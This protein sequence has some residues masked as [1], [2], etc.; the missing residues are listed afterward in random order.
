MSESAAYKE[1]K[2]AKVL[3][4]SLVKKPQSLVSLTKGIILL[5]SMLLL[6]ALHSEH[7]ATSNL[8]WIDQGIKENNMRPYQ[9]F[10]A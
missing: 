8:D 3:A 4:G 9:G 2:E 1:L 5:L 6:L 7:E 10:N